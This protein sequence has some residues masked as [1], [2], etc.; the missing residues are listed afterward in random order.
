MTS[1]NLDPI[2]TLAPSVMLQWVFT[3]TFMQSVR[4]VLTSAPPPLPYLR[5]VI[6]ERSLI[7]YQNQSV[8]RETALPVLRPSL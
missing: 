8:A 7:I 1:S 2:L 6:Y 3:Y 4:K 5:D